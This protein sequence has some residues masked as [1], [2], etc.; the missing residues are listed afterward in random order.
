MI[1]IENHFGYT[2]EIGLAGWGTGLET[3]IVRR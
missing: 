2:V 3:M 1:R